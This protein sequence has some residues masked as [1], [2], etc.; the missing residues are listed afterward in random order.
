MALRFYQ[1]ALEVIM[2][3]GVTV[4]DVCKTTY[5]EIKKDKKHRY[6]IFYI[7]DEKQ[8]DVETVADRNAEYDQFLEDIQKCGPGECRYGLFDFEYMHQCQGTSE[9]SKKQKLFLMSWCP[10]TA[11]VK[12]KMLYSSSFDALKKSLVGVQKYIQATDLSEASPNMFLS[13]APPLMDFEDELLWINQTNSE[14][15]EILYDKSNYVT[16][17]TKHLIEQAFLQ[18]LSLQDQHIL[19]DDL[20]KQ[21]TDIARQLT[22]SGPLPTE[23]IHLY[24]SNCISTCETVKDK[25]MQSR[26][27][28]LVCVF[29]QSLIRNKIVNV[30]E[31]FIEIEAFCVGFSKIKEAAAL[32]RLIKHLE[33][34]ESALSSNSLSK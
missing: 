22:T 21:N 14:K 9:S 16:P 12:K 29:L 32:Y 4:S 26:L 1:H 10:D 7:R 2:A 30:K 27:V 13:I 17:N 8:I 6:V 33:T 34:G 20:L 5:E 28:R 3:S 24:I 25:Y 11:K 19:F 23:F 31:L 15:V 18:P